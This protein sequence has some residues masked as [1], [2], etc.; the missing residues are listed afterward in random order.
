MDTGSGGF[1]ANDA[2]PLVLNMRVHLEKTFDSYTTTMTLEE[3]VNFVKK[4]CKFIKTWS[5]ETT[6]E[7]S[8]DNKAVGV[9]IDKKEEGT[10]AALKLN[11]LIVNGGKPGDHQNVTVKGRPYIAIYDGTDDDSIKDPITLESLSSGGD[12]DGGGDS[13]QVTSIDNSGCS[14]ISFPAGL[15]LLL[16]LILLKK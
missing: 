6:A 15:L 14:L 12:E 2:L 4:N 8:L 9:S 3:S 10:F 7:I 1:V 16:P 5:D 13:T 11:T